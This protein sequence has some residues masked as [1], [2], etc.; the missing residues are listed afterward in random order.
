[1]P[2]V[3]ELLRQAAEYRRLAPGCTTPGLAEML[4]T[5]A[6]DLEHAAAKLGQTTTVQQQ[7]IQPPEQVYD[8][9]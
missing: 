2:T 3:E 5:L 4:L 9:E 6:G 8:T 7:Q 1:V